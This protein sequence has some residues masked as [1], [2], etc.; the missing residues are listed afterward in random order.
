ML[1]MVNYAEPVVLNHVVLCGASGFES[2]SVMLSRWLRII[3]CYAEPV[4]VNNGKL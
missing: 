1:I 4:V 3:M 2:L